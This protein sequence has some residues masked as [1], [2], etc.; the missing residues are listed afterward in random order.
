[1]LNRVRVAVRRLQN[2]MKKRSAE[3]IANTEKGA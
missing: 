3:C 1:M 2:A